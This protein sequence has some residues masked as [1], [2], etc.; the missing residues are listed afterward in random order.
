MSY[1]QRLI[2]LDLES[3]EVRRLRQDLLLTY[4]I[5]FGL[6]N[7]D[8]SKFFTLG[9]NSITRGH[10]FKLCLSHS[11]VD[12]RKYFFVSVLSRNV[13]FIFAVLQLKIWINWNDI[14]R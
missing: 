4:K 12:V 13:M 10:S 3:L 6:I 11:R 9:R 7:I 8:S 1:S 5:V 2:S 14:V